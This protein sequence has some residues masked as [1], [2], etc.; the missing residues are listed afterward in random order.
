MRSAIQRALMPSKKMVEAD[1]NPTVQHRRTPLCNDSVCSIISKT[2]KDG[3]DDA[4][5]ILLPTD[6]KPATRA[7]AICRSV[8]VVGGK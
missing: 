4:C 7:D 5:E 2:I 8:I 3:C 6:A 1:T